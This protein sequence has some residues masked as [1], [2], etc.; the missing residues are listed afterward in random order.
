MDLPQEEYDKN[1]LVLAN[2][3]AKEMRE[4]DVGI[5]MKLDQKVIILI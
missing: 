4:F 2:K 3:H 5:I 1:K